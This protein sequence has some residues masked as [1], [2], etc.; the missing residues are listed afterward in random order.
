[1]GAELFLAGALFIIM[2]GMG[3]GLVADDFKRVLLYPKAVAI[4][5]ALKVLLLPAIMFGIL[6]LLPNQPVELAVGFVLLAACP[7]GATSNLIAGLCRSDVA[8][9]IT[10]T[11]FA[12]FITVLTIP[13]FT[14]LA[15]S[16]L[17]GGAA[18]VSLPIGET[19]IK[20]IAITVLPVSIGMLVKRYK[21]ALADRADKPVR[22]ISALLLLIIII[23]IVA[24]NSEHLGALFSKAGPLSVLMNVIALGLGYGVSRLL[25]L[26]EKQA[27]T[28]SIETGI[29]NSTLAIAI[30]ST[31]GTGGFSENGYAFAAAVYSLVMYGSITLLVW[32]GNKR[33]KDTPQA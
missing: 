11:A 9:S 29:I 5:L 18:S 19:M 12:S 14:E 6:M 3:L 7:G 10:L 28:I 16:Q 4:G 8:L 22:I 15:L 24:K 23:A 20:I 27:V 1:M 25:G 31:L 30:A 33:L 26:T 21:P 2:I 32:Y 17:G 13:L